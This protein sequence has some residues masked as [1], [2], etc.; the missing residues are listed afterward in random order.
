MR[1]VTQHRLIVFNARI[2]K[3]QDRCNKFV[4]KRRVWKLQQ[5][6]LL[7]DKFCETFAGEINYTSGDRVDNIWTRLKQGLLSPTEKTCGWA[8]KDI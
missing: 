2:V 3:S 8:R 6:D 7:H 4:A 5:D 1:S